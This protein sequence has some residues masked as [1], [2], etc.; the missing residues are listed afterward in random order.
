MWILYETGNEISKPTSDPISQDPA[1]D[2]VLLDPANIDQRG[3]GS[4]CVHPGPVHSDG[5][6]DLGTKTETLAG[7]LFEPGK[8]GWGPGP[9]GRS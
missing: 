4:T 2:S 3:P 9:G 1:D 8:S 5:T 7:S 6:K